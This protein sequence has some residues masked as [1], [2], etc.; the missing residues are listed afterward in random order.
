MRLLTDRKRVSAFV[1]PIAHLTREGERRPEEE[2]TFCSNNFSESN[3]IFYP[4]ESFAAS[5]EINGGQGKNRSEASKK[6]AARLSTSEPRLPRNV[7]RILFYSTLSMCRCLAR[8]M[9]L[10]ASWACNVGASTGSSSHWF[11]SRRTMRSP[12]TGRMT[13]CGGHGDGERITWIVY[14]GMYLYIY[15]YF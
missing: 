10:A 2:D 9:T 8:T 7:R 3:E 5:E 15:L 12:G 1:W 6:S 11:S 13:T 4:E 14:I